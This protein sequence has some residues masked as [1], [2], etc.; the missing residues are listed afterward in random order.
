MNIG[1]FTKDVRPEKEP[2][3]GLTPSMEGTSSE[4]PTVFGTNLDNELDQKPDGK[5][6]RNLG[7]TEVGKSSMISQLSKKVAEKRQRKR[8][9]RGREKIASTV[10]GQEKTTK[11][12]SK[13]F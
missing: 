6:D 7:R 10:P 2:D 8:Q 4:A 13:I 9:R 11:P 5:N 3:E 1:P 12:K